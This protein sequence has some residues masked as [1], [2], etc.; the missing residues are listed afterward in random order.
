MPEWKDIKMVFD[1][2][3]AKAHHYNWEVVQQYPDK[4]RKQ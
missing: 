3:S 2:T 1:A 4:N